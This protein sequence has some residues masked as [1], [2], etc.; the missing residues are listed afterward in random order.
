MER[1]SNLFKETDKYPNFWKV[2]KIDISPFIELLYLSV[3]FRLHLRE[4]LEIWNHES[5]HKI[6]STKIPYNWF[7]FICKIIT[8]DDKSTRNKQ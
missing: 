8:F 3:V 4:T 6:S 2:G 1:F 5:S 7:Q